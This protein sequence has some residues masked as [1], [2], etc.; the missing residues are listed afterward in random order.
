MQNYLDAKSEKASLTIGVTAEVADILKELSEEDCRSLSAY[1][2]IVLEN[3]IQSG[4]SHVLP[5][6]NSRTEI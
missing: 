5:K 1:C 2:R 6:I 4:L 3:H